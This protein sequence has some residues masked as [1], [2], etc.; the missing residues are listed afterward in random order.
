M[1]WIVIVELL[2]FVLKWGV[3]K[4]FGNCSILL[5]SVVVYLIWYVFGLGNVI[6]M[7]VKVGWNLVY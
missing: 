5:F 7:Y 3:V 1:M 6:R 4:L 2:F